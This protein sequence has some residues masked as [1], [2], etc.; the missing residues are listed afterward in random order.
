MECEE[1]IFSQGNGRFV[2]PHEVEVDGERIS[3]ERFLIVIPSRCVV[4]GHRYGRLGG[5]AV[6]SPRQAVAWSDHRRSER[7]DYFVDAGRINLSLNWRT[8]SFSPPRR[9][10]AS[11]NPFTFSACAA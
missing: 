10:F 4:P 8:H 9:L 3:G 5:S 2:S 6:A 1:S 11:G 7:V